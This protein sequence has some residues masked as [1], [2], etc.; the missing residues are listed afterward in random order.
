ME[1]MTPSWKTRSSQK[2]VVGALD[3]L[4][5]DVAVAV[6][7]VGNLELW[8]MKLVIKVKNIKVKNFKAVKIKNDL[9]ARL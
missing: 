1:L 5:V 9:E 2:L 6:D 8:E 4:D 3:V 7:V